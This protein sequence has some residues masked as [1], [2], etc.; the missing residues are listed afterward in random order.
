MEWV[1][2]Q[3]SKG[4]IDRSGKALMTPIETIDDLNNYSEALSVI[5]NWRASH[6]YPHAW[7]TAVE[8]VGTFLKQPLKSSLGEEQWLR[9]FAVVGSVIA[10]REGAT[11][12]VPNTP[13]NK[14]QL[15]KELRSL[16][17]KLN[18]TST[19]N[20]FGHALSVGENA[21]A[22]GAHYFLLKLE[23]SQQKMTV[24]G[25]PK[26]NLEEASKK[27]LEVEKEIK[28]VPGADAVL[29]SVDS[30]T[31]LKRAYPNYFLD[32]KVFL[33]ELEDALSGN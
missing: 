15:I 6:N 3:Y 18:V 16:S 9:F 13:T 7:A 33:G 22:K 21:S 23:P 20:M 32:T 8:T 24:T 27:Y 30:L 25:F 31:A 5:S 11:T 2:P 26:R 17:K 1:R 29:V 10:L 12:L 28:D 14:A 19:L 4:K